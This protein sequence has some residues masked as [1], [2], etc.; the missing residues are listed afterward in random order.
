[1]DARDG[2]PSPGCI[3]QRR[4]E[5][6]ALRAPLLPR[7][8]RAAEPDGLAPRPAVTPDGTPRQ[9]RCAQR[10]A[11]Q[12]LRVGGFVPFTSTDYPD[13][14]AAVVFCQGCPWRCGYCH[15]PHLIPARG[16]DERD[17]ARILD[18]LASRRGL[19]DA[20]VFSG[21]EP[22]AQAGIVR[23]GRRGAR[24][25]LRGR[26]PHRRRVSAPARAGAARSSTG[27][28]ST[29][30]RRSPNMRR[31]PASRKRHQR[32]REPRP[33]A[34]RGLRL[35]GAD[36]R[37]SGTD[38]AGRAAAAR[39]R[40]RRAPRRALGPAG[41]SRDRL[42]ERGARCGWIETRHARS[43]LALEVAC[44]CSGNRTARLVNDGSQTRPEQPQP[45]DQTCPTARIVRHG[46]P[47]ATCGTMHFCA[48][49]AYDL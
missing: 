8:S 4:Q 33:R 43:G 34:R 6:R 11:A 26:A 32:A 21:G 31:S 27:S 12:A 10:T 47:A 48:P 28:A 3:V 15:N 1:M 18:W 2:L 42:R 37:P 16:D 46:L 36:D 49:P 35:R 5:G 39:A 20:V 40:A 45:E 14:L 19:L 24:A 29:S 13:A 17:F 23:R 30:R 38:A 9:R 7:G 25:G 41:I 22:T 44:A